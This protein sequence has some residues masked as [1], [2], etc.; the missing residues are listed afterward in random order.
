MCYDPGNTLGSEVAVRKE[1]RVDLVVAEVFRHALGIL[2]PP[3]DTVGHHAFEID[4]FNVHL[5]EL[6]PDKFLLPNGLRVRE[7][8]LPER[9]Q[10][11][12][13]T[14]SSEHRSHLLQALHRLPLPLQS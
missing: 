5:G 9:T 1:Q 12:S 6:C 3:D 8:K 11:K 10:P 4:G 13:N 2:L 14:L 7:D